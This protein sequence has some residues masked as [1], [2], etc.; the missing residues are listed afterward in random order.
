MRA[1]C[2]SFN[3]YDVDGRDEKIISLSYEVFPF[4]ILKR[5]QSRGF[6]Y[7][8]NAILFSLFLLAVHTIQPV[9]GS[10]NS[11]FKFAVVIVGLQ[12]K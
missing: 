4:E 11:A 3:A 9:S 10:I 2:E 8:L 6:T 5:T 1:V 12:V 7:C